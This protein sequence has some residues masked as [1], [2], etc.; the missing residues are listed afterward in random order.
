MNM[1]LIKRALLN[2]VNTVENKDELNEVIEAIS[3]I[4]SVIDCDID[5]EDWDYEAFIIPAFTW[6][7][8]LNNMT[9]DILGKRMRLHKGDVPMS[10]YIHDVREAYIGFDNIPN[11]YFELG[12]EVIKDLW[13]NNEQED[14]NNPDGTFKK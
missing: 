9:Y 1:N 2:Y 3:E 8:V 6:D 11:S 5:K 4:N 7:N 12:Y 10:Y 13:Q 14:S